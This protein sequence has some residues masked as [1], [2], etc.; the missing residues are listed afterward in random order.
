M[1]I[2]DILHV[3]DGLHKECKDVLSFKNKSYKGSDTPDDALSNMKRMAKT[4]N[5]TPESIIT[6]LIEKHYD[7]IKQQSFQD[8]DEL[9]ERICDIINYLTIYYCFHIEEGYE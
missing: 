1:T 2:N 5:S 3:S 6:V 7:V 4:L 8:Y 9:S